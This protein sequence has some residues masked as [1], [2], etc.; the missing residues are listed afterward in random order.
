[1][2]HRQQ[3]FSQQCSFLLEE[4]QEK[5][6]YLLFMFQAQT[7]MFKEYQLQVL[8][9]AKAMAKALLESGYSLVSGMTKH[10]IIIFSHHIHIADYN[11]LFVV[12]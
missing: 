7:P 9:N 2:I 4:Q 11:L 3:R 6:V 12:V 5:T 8:K 1:M 10:L